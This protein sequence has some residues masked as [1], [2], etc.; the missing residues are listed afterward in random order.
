MNHNSPLRK[1]TVHISH[2]VIK[3]IPKNR[4]TSHFSRKHGL[5]VAISKLIFIKHRKFLKFLVP[6][7]LQV[8]M[9]RCAGTLGYLSLFSGVWK[10]PSFFNR[11]SWKS[12][13]F[14]KNVWET[15]HS[16]SPFEI[17]HTWNPGKFLSR[18]GVQGE[19]LEGPWR[20]LAG[21]WD[22]KLL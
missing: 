8:P 17:Q 22:Q 14:E 2:P 19:T 5:V 15:L 18:S 21:T 9:P 10:F 20:N 1:T 3:R 4:V 11:F 13:G 12:F 6:G 16:I 7:T